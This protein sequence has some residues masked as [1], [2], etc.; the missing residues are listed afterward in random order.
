MVIKS[1][2]VGHASNSRKIR[3][4]EMVYK[5]QVYVTSP[6]PSDRW[7]P[8]RRVPQNPARSAGFAQAPRL[9]SIGLRDHFD[10]NVAHRKDIKINL[11]IFFRFW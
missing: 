9:I 1:K 11:N 4:S 8:A 6:E 5:E 2:Y 7:L 10:K 3:K